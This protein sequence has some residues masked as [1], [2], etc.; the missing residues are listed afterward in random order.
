M[1]TFGERLKAL[2]EEKKLT[3]TYIAELLGRTHRHYQ[4]IEYGKV[5]I[6][7]LSLLK[8][9]DFF[10]VSADYLL[11]RTDKREINK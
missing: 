1:K 2:R 11:G 3:Q 9:A 7:A 4:E 10:D 8:L 6:S 5:N